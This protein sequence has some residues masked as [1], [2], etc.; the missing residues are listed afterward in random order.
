MVHERAQVLADATLREILRRIVA[1]ID[2]DRIILF[3]SRAR[4][5][6][7]DE[8]DFDLLAIKATTERALKLE[9][10]AYMALLGLTT[11]VDL[12]VETPERL[13]RLRDA[14]GLIYGDAL[15]E[16]TVVYERP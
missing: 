14:P 3:G 11:S 10:T 2:P 1:A 4:G 13:E 12:L 7:R 6:A 8:S 5:G 9:Q 16:G 15:R